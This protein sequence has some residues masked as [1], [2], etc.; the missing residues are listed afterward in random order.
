MTLQLALSIIGLVLGIAGSVVLAFSLN[1]LTAE[2]V[3]CL[4]LVDTTVGSLV[5]SH[6]IPR[7][8]GIDARLNDGVASAKNRTIGGVLLLAMGFALQLVTLFMQ[9]YPNA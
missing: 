4:Q 8:T 1:K 3:L 5:S 2:L 9:A 6:E 7:F